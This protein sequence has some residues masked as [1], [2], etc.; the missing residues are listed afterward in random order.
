MSIQVHV[1]A[2]EHAKT[3][4]GLDAP[5][6]FLQKKPDENKSVALNGGAMMLDL[7]AL[8]STAAALTPN[9]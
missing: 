6:Y 4:W 2:V 8:L 1:Q 3:V 7:L 5:V 9:G